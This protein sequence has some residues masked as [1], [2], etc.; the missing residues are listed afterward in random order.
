MQRAGVR[1]EK[2]EKRR[3]AEEMRR[4]REGVGQTHRSRPRSHS[5]DGTTSCKVRT[6]KMALLLLSVH[7]LLNQCLLYLHSM[8]L[9]D[10][11]MYLPRP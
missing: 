1:E 7:L 3:P 10:I 2:E 11:P 6:L 9:T 8:H 5:L 4:R